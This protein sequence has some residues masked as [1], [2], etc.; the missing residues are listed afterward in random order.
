MSK[1]HI[2][3]INNLPEDRTDIQKVKKLTERQIKRAAASDADAPL[4]TQKELRQF[5]RVHPPVFVDVKKMRNKLHISQAV[6]AAY[7]GVSLRTLQ[8]WEQGKRVP[9]GP[10]RIL[11][12]LIQRKPQL[13]REVLTEK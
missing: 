11:L 8:D 5:K 4:L 6:F 10:A 13:V 9:R 12:R 7:F 3:T 1:K 2:Y